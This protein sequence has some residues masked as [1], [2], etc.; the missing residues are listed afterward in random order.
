MST[1]LSALSI[2][3]DVDQGTLFSELSATVSKGNRIGL[4]GHNGCGKTTF[5]KLLNRELKPNSGNITQSNQCL[6]GVVEQV[7]PQHLHKL[8]LQD[9]LLHQLPENLRQSEAWRTE[10]LLSQI[11]FSESDWQLTAGTL[12][13]GQHTRLL[14]ARALINEPDLL[15][16]DEP[17]NHLDLPTL[18]WLEAFLGA[19]QGSYVLVSHDQR[20]LDN[21]T[22]CT[23]IMRDQKLHFFALPCSAARQ[24]LEQ[25]DEADHA[26]RTAEQNEIDRITKSAKRLA[27]WGHVY[28]NE[29]LSRKAKTM[30][31]RIDRLKDEQTELTEGTPWQLALNGESLPANRLLEV[32]NFAVKPEPNAPTLFEIENFQIKSHQRIAIVGENGAGKSSLIRSLWKSYETNEPSINKPG[33]TTE[34]AKQN[35]HLLSNDLHFHP[36]LRL[37]Y[38]DQSLEQLDNADSLIEA[39][40]KFTDANE[41]I[42]KMSLIGAGFDF[43]RHS[44][45]VAQLS[46]GERARLLFVGLS[47]A[48]YHLIFLDEPTNHLDLEG[49]Q[50]LTETLQEFPGGVILVSHDRDLIELACTEYWMIKDNKLTRWLDVN[51]M[52]DDMHSGQQDETYNLTA[53]DTQNVATAQGWSNAKD[54]DELLARLVELEDKLEADKARRPNRQKPK[55]QALW[56]TEIEAINLKLETL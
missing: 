41:R 45:K 22:N 47:L 26:R 5:L 29:D 11:G 17:S 32:A 48:N 49:K 18:L 34:Q 51:K 9:A 16:L 38:Y 15:L 25:K 28:D 2:S 46:G 6:L 23:W 13:G 14:L 8:T 21:V 1:L 20:L 40:G 10:V 4:I 39:L 19:W 7:L 30:E 36:K 37:G 56:Q 24:A 54:E 44:Q 55:L 33:R 50:E 42:C 27:H 35:E 31:K 43:T 53:I 3:Y 52:Y 12:S